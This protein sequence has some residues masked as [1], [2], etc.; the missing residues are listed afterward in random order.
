MG[1]Q[2]STDV[3]NSVMDGEIID[4]IPLPE[5][6]EARERL[7]FEDT[8]AWLRDDTKTQ[9]PISLLG[10]VYYKFEGDE[11]LRSHAYSMELEIDPESV[12][13]KPVT[14]QELLVNHETAAE[15]GFL[16]FVSAKVGATEVLEM[17][18]VDNAAA[19]AKVVGKQWME[20]LDR[21][22]TRQK[23]QPIAGGRKLLFCAVVTG[24]VQ[25]YVS[26]KRF[27]EFEASGKGGGYGVNVGGRLY[28]SSSGFELD[29]VHGLSLQDLLPFIQSADDVDEDAVEMARKAA[30]GSTDLDLDLKDFGVTPGPVVS[31]MFEDEVLAAPSFEF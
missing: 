11:E 31:R 29:I 1:G 7:G 17:R 5:P 22:F 30:E 28:V 12:L 24:V 6:R 27:S 4:R 20:E 2:H 3:V 16:S 13:K 23:T 10:R 19:S 9:S 26:T 15:A 8:V 21:W 25:K 14:R 18:V